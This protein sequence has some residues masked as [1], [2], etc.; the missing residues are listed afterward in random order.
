[1]VGF[2]GGSGFLIGVYLFVIFLASIKIYDVPYLYPL[3]PFDI[4]E[5]R[6]VVFRGVSQS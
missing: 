6:K 2:F 5:L 4:N 3:F 1:M